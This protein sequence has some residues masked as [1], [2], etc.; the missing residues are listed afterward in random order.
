MTLTEKL[1]V[2]RGRGYYTVL[3]AILAS[4]G[5]QLVADANAIKAESGGKLTA[6]DVGCLAMKYDLNL[7]A[8]CEWLEES[9]TL[10]V[11]TYDRLKRGGLKATEVF[12]E[13]TVG[14]ALKEA[15]AAGPNQA[16]G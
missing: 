12:D 7:K 2:T 4:I 8:T 16:R 1:R 6:Y 3:K 10:P 15:L 11:G 9:R 14:Q 13:V 5:P